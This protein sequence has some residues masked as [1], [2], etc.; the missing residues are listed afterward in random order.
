MQPKCYVISHSLSKVIDECVR[1]LVKYSWNFE[2]FNAVDGRKLTDRDWASIGVVMSTEGKMT[3]RPG[4]QG[5]WMSH[6]HLWNRCVEINKPIV[7]MEHDAV[8]TDVWPE[9]LDISAK[10]IKLYRHAECKINPAFG[11]W[12]KG[13]HAYTI[14]P[15]QAQR[16]ISY[17]RNNGAQ[18]VDKHLGDLVL[19]WSFMTQDLVILNPRR[20]QS[21]TNSIVRN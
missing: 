7:I 11:R 10:L 13:S 5:C 20:G 15:E 18:A 17:A 19:P 21:S 14:T 1:S 16:L 2:I 8:V 12:S 9:S 3:K 6:W 4:A